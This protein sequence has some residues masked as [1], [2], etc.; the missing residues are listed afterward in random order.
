MFSH[1]LIFEYER[2][3]YRPDDCWVWPSMDHFDHSFPFE[4]LIP[5]FITVWVLATAG[6]LPIINL[7][8]MDQTFI[9]FRVSQKVHLSPGHERILPFWRYPHCPG[10]NSWPIMVQWPLDPGLS[11]KWSEIELWSG[12]WGVIMRSDQWWSVTGPAVIHPHLHSS[13]RP[14]QSAL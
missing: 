14:A 13:Q 2:L 4:H 7:G 12:E 5:I 1:E 11:D 10:A 8:S 6:L 3:V 9:A